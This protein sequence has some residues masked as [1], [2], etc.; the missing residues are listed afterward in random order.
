METIYQYILCNFLIGSS[1][2]FGFLLSGIFI[3][4]ININKEESPSD[5]E[6]EPLNINSF[7]EELEYEPMSNLSNQD[8]ECLKQSEVVLSLEPLTKQTIRMYYDVDENTFFY[9]SD[10]ETIYKY[11]EIVARYYVIQYHC[12]QIFT[13]LDNA[14]LKIISEPVVE[15]NNAFISKKNDKKI[16]EKKFIRF[17]Y[18]GNEN[19][20]QLQYKKNNPT[21]NNMSILEFL[22]KKDENKSDSDIKE[23][24]TISKED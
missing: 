1:I 24:E 8:L 13:E 15:K 21:T 14:K 10:R 6:D 19:D 2:V 7:L 12:K 17:V 9:Y 11:L 16:L 23:Y 4:R 20:Y 3:S 18:K 22:K 5:Q